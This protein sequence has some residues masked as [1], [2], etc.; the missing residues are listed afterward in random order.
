MLGSIA[1]PAIDAVA[2]K[3]K[4]VMPNMK[5]KKG[6]AATD[7]KLETLQKDV[8]NATKTTLKRFA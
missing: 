1:V 5:K 6:G 7:P 8:Y 2:L 4:S 3:L